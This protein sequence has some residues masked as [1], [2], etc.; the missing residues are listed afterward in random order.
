MSA[1]RA[2]P[3]IGPRL[4]EKLLLLGVRS[5][6]DLRG[7][8]PE[9]LYDEL[10]AQLGPV[11]R[12]VLYAF[13]CAVHAAEH[14]ADDGRTQGGGHGAANPELAKWWNWKDGGPALRRREAGLKQPRPQAAAGSRRTSIASR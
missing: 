8:D 12:C 3:S 10:R 6:D 11:D 9:A 1:L 14:A 13:R 4:A 5:P 7:H 2:L